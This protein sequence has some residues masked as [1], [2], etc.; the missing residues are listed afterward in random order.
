MR[1]ASQRRKLAVSMVFAGGSVLARRSANA[2]RQAVLPS[3]FQDFLGFLVG[4]LGDSVFV[5]LEQRLRAVVFD[6]EAIDQRR[7]GPAGA[8]AAQLVLE[9]V[10]GLVHAF[11]GV[12]EDFVGGHGGISMFSACV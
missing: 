10:G 3:L 1:F 2:K 7:R 4:H 5:G 6:A 11:F 12:E 9:H 8:Q